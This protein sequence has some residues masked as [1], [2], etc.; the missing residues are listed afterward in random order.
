MKNTDILISGAGI[1]GAALAYWL[2][3]RGFRPT[4]V[5]R[6]RL[7]RPGGQ[8]VDLR[9]AGR[10]VIER[11]GLMDDVRDVTL[12][13]HG[14]AYVDAA[15]RIRA[16]MGVDDF[17]GEGVV[18]EIEVLRGD[19]A[20]VLHRA[21]LPGTE[22]VYGDTI[23]GL[24]QDDDGVTVTFEQAAPRRFGMVI[25]AD[26]LHS[27]VRAI[28][29][30]PESRTTRP[31]GGYI[32]WF[33]AP[34]DIDLHGWYLMYNAPGGLVASARP[35]R[36]PHEIK[37]GF[38][39]RSDPIAY[40]RGDVDRQREIV[41]QRF[42]GVGWEVPKL[43]AAM[44]EAPDFAFDAMS[45][46]HLDRWSAGRVALL[47]DAGYCATPLTGLG[48]SLA[49]VG[50]YVLA[51]EL[52][53]ADGEHRVAFGRYEDVMRPYVAEAQKLPPGGIGGYAPTRRI[54][55]ALRTASV[56]LMT[57]RPLRSLMAAQFAKAGN[58]ALPDYEPAV[59]R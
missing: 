56:R 53:A 8:A 24:D 6:A 25:G 57:R 1:A 45:Q 2:R 39:F 29:F 33:T 35:G 51:G 19:L 18:S 3:E 23:T 4:V 21:T 47:G 34:A 37:A 50:A 49:L 10:T 28:A 58:N 43:V 30:G 52:A 20:E 31:I 42:A 22:Y 46:V 59:V 38:G 44:R 5:E 16:R 9:G 40:D 48:T 12:D 54:D 41:A 7:P 11:M 32:S 17:G 27:A 13:Q 26:G 36:L 14:I 15:G 55:I